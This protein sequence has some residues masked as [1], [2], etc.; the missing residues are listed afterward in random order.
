MR[1]A[2]LALCLCATPIAAGG[3]FAADL[4]AAARTQLEAA[5]KIPPDEQ[6]LYSARQLRLMLAVRSRS[7]D[8]SEAKI[9]RRI[10]RIKKGR[11]IGIELP[12]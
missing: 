8:T 3:A 12:L 10:E 4:P 1:H 11:I 5:A 6:G 9:E 2:I 7:G